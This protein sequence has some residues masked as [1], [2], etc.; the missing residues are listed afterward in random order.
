MSCISLTTSSGHSTSESTVE[1]HHLFSSMTLLPSLSA[2]AASSS[3]SSTKTNGNHASTSLITTTTPSPL[4]LK[5]PTV[6]IVGCPFSGGQRK[7]GVDTGPHQLISA[8]LV[9]QIEE[10][11]WKVHF[12]GEEKVAQI[13]QHWSG[14]DPDIGIMKNPRT[15]S[16]VAQAVSDRVYG[17]ASSG[18]LPRRSASGTV[19]R[20]GMRRSNEILNKMIKSRN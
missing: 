8:G 2:P 3:S 9:D 12:D 7:G 11:G 14:R 15:V 20:P 6:Q 16:A 5:S 19:S 10:L 18:H 1:L 13:Q 17:I 4:H